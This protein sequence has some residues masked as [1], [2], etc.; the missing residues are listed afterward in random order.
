MIELAKESF[1][2]PPAIESR[3]GFDIEDLNLLGVSS[4][5]VIASCPFGHI[6]VKAESSGKLE[7]AE[8]FR[9]VISGG[10][11]LLPSIQG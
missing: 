7:T 1:G 3:D 2:D 4:D 8:D 10:Q 6:F 11:T 9:K 5:L